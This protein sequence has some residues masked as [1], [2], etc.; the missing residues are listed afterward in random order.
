MPLITALL[1]LLGNHGALA[2]VRTVLDQRQGEDWLVASLALRLD[3]R[4]RTGVAKAATA[5]A[6]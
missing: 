3:E 2:N 5:D 6:A 4:E 1:H